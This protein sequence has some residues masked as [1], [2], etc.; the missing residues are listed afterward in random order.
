MAELLIVVELVFLL[1]S[2]HNFIIFEIEGK[3]LRR[4]FF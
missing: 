3:L 2:V 4:L 1:G